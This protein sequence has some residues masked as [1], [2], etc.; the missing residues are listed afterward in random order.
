M[1][2][3]ADRDLLDGAIAVGAPL[4]RAHGCP[5]C[6]GL[7]Y[8]GRTGIY[9]V[10]T[11]DREMEALIHRGAA[12]AELVAHARRLGPSLIEDGV[13]KIGQGITTVEE[14]ARVAQER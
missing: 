4:R 7:G 1:A 10:V 14:V 5:A 11:I 2:T 12:E 13:R 8:R 3:A 9:E 6:L